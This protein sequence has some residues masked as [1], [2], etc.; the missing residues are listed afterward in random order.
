MNQPSL[1]NPRAKIVR[2]GEHLD[3]LREELRGFV[4]RDPHAVALE[5]DPEEGWRVAR[6]R[7][8]EEPPLRLSLIL[9]DFVHNLRS[10]LDNLVCQLAGLERATDCTTTQF[11]ICDT[12]QLFAQRMS[13]GWLAGVSD[14][15]VATVEELQPYPGRDSATP[16]A[17][18]A[19]RD[20]DNIDKHRA[21]H[22]MVVAVNPDPHALGVSRE[23]INTEFTIEFEYVTVGKPLYDG[24]VIAR[25]R[26]GSRESQPKMNMQVEFPLRIG[27]GDAGLSMDALP[28]IWGEIRSIVELFARIFP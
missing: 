2:A 14:E 17:L 25:M 8:H 11:P 5:D 7:V 10:G 15:H 16:R 3:A 20:F 1:Q 27:F 6:F 21:I 13:R 23:P 24:A 28:P 26:A 18:A 12:P 9:G 22:A 4:D 19:I